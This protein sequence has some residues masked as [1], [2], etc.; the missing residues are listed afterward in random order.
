MERVEQM[1]LAGR[2]D[3]SAR[4]ADII[5]DHV[6]DFLEALRGAVEV[7]RKRRCDHIGH[8]FMFG[9]RV[10]FILRE[11]TQADAILK[12]DHQIPLFNRQSHHVLMVHL[13]GKLSSTSGGIA[14]QTERM[15]HITKFDLC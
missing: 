2:I 11:P 13:S 9:N 6:A 3:I 5:N 8:M 4:H 12:T 14:R 15:G 1:R 10:N 7:G